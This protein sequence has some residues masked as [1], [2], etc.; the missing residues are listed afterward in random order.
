MKIF[1]HEVNRIDAFNLPYEES[2]EIKFSKD[3]E[4]YFFNSAFNKYL[5]KQVAVLFDYLEEECR[6]N[7]IEN[8]K[9]RFSKKRY[10]NVPE[11]VA[12]Q[13]QYSLYFINVNINKD[14]W[15]DNIEEFI[16][17]NLFSFGQLTFGSFCYV[18]CLEMILEDI[19]LR[20]MP[21]EKVKKI[22]NHI[23]DTYLS[24]NN[25]ESKVK[26]LKLIY[27]RWLDTFP[28]NITFFENLKDYY[29]N[30]FPFFLKG[31]RNR[32]TGRISV[33]L[34]NEKILRE[35]LLDISQ[36][37]LDS[38]NIPKL[39]KEGILT[40]LQSK[41]LEFMDATLDTN[42]RKLL[43][44]FSEG[45]LKYL[46]VI[47]TWLSYH[48]KY[49]AMAAPL[50]KEVN[51]PIAENENPVK[52]KPNDNLGSKTRNEIKP[53]FDPSYVDTIFEVLKVHFEPNRQQE[54]KCLFIQGGK[55]ENKLYFM[56]NGNKLADTFKKLIE[57]NMITNC[58]KKELEKWILTNFQ[59]KNQS[60]SHSNKQNFKARTL[61][62]IISNKLAKAPCKNPLIEISN[63]VIIKV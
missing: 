11:K 30:R 13:V 62:D 35:F 31:R 23:L 25:E 5:L 17:Y 1:K 45:E 44:Q 26:S 15:L 24:V 20:T 12:N 27:N 41:Q 3:Y 61:Q 55:L 58:S 53:V 14:D 38:I 59:F 10:K 8:E 43:N 33:E 29:K 6:V 21:E 7:K 63:G 18:C 50:L 22:R 36:Q 51:I 60:N 32:Y 16:E 56:N 40:N 49:F 46:N 42:T 34:I 19:K 4:V 57:H 39:R 9:W 28:F 48:Q 54:L 52:V 2:Y 47:E 37:I